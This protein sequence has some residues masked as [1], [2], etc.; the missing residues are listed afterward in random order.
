QNSNENLA[1]NS[2]SET[3]FLLIVDDTFITRKLLQN[4]FE[5]EFIILQAENGEQAMDILLHNSKVSIIL[6]DMNM[7]IMNGFEFLRKY[8]YHDTIS[9]IP[10]VVITADPTLEAEALRNGA[11]DMIVKPFDVNVVKLRV[12]NALNYSK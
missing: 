10:V 11:I 7:P 4:Y 2:I 5:D 8:K 1:D 9:K 12:H 3:P 6:L